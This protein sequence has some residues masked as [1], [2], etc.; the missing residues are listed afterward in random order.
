MVKNLKIYKNFNLTEKDKRSIILSGNRDGLHRGHQK[1]FN[2]AK[3]FKKKFKLRIGVITF[4]T[5]PKRILKKLYKYRL[6]NFD[7]KI[8]L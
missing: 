6:S 2:N 8:Q 1:L 5:I 7:D 3:S 4:D